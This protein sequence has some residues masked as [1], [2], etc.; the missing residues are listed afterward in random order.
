MLRCRSAVLIVFALASVAV[1]ASTPLSSRAAG[2]RSN[3]SEWQRYIVKDEDFSVLLPAMPAMTTY[4]T[5]VDLTRSR[6]ERIIAAY[7]NGVVYSVNSYEKKSISLG[8][9]VARFTND[10]SSLPGGRVAVEGVS[11]RSFRF[12]DDYFMRANEI[13]E[14]SKHLYIFSVIGAKIGDPVSGIPRF[15][16]SIS[17]DNKRTGIE[18]RDGH[19]D[20]PDTTA[21]T[22]QPAEPILRGKD[23]THKARVASK[24]EPHYT[25]EARRHQVTGTVVLRAVFS[26]SG[27]VTNIHVVSTLPDGLTDRAIEAARQIRF[28]PASKDG[29]FVSMWMELQYNFNLY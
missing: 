19:G 14:T 27:S 4:T 7:E 3:P 9:L 25:E 15:F 17:F 18:I 22:N 2:D 12:E 26:A 28:I 16:S 1:R 10:G 29:R 11:G 6:R 5:Y 21:Q 20:Q 23:V 13:F 8:D 24:P